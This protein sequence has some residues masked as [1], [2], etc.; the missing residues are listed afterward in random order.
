VRDN[1]LVDSAPS[2][3]TT[4]AFAHGTVSGKKVVITL[5]WC[6]QRTLLYPASRNSMN[7]DKVWAYCPHCKH[8]QRFVRME[9]LHWV[10]AILTVVTC[11]LW[12][13]SWAA[14]VIGQ[15]FIPWRCKHC[16]WSYPDFSKI[17]KSRS[18]KSEPKT[19]V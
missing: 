5:G 11:G 8:T 1:V 12:A 18:G 4:M 17:R 19:E 9:I 2:A 3:S 7:P 13:V 14:L 6:L 16:G 15:R 10:H